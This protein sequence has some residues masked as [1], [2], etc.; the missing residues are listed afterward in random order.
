M[1][2]FGQQLQSREEAARRSVA[3]NLRSLGDI[4][5]GR[6]PRNYESDTTSRETI[7]Q[8][9]LILKYFKLDIPEKP[10]E[11]ENILEQIDAL[12][13]PSGAMRRR[14]ILSGSWWKDGDGPILATVKETGRVL[15]LLPGLLDGYYYLDPQ[16]GDKIRITKYNRGLFE[17]DA[18]C[19]YKPLPQESLTG[20]EYIAFLLQQ[21]RLSDLILL[22]LAGL[23]VT[24]VGILIPLVTKIAFT[25]IVPTGKVKM[26][27]SLTLM[28]ASTAVGGWLM[29]SV[30]DSMTERIRNRLDTSAQNAVFSRLLN[31]PVTFF[32]NK[33]SGGLAQQVTALN[34]LPS[35]LCD[36]LLCGMLTVVLSLADIYPIFSASVSL[37]LPSLAVLAASVGLFWVTVLQER[38]KIRS[39]LSAS[40]NNNAIVYDFLMGI[41]KIKLSGSENMA[42][43]KWL[44]VYNKKAG[45]FFKVQFPASIRGQLLTFIRLLGTLWTFSI[46][47]RQGLSAAQFAVFASAYGL[48]MSGIDTL[49]LYGNSFSCL[50]PVLNIGEPILQEVPEQSTG[51]RT[52]SS[53]TGKIELHEVT[54]RYFEDGPAILDNV[55]LSI[56]P[57]EYVAIVGTTGCGKSTFMKLLLG[58]LSPQQGSITY[59]DKDLE[60]IDKR[61]FRRHVG[62]VLQD[63]KLFP[64]DILDNITIAAPWLTPDDAWEA[65]QK[66]GIADYIRSLPMGMNTFITEG[67]GSISGGQRQR[68]II[69][70][71]IATNANILMFDEATSALDNI[72]QKVVTDSL[73]K[74][75][76]T[77]I[78]I[79]HRLS[80]IRDCDRILV[81]DQ[82]KIAESGT[83]DELIARKGFFAELVSRQLLSDP[84]FKPKKL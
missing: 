24:F 11:Y 9:G 20:R 3:Q 36:I 41:Q 33:S 48:M 53:L 66:A 76:C 4:V 29:R 10:P 30:R 58:F 6:K 67:S 40:V 74:M 83:Y 26:L 69:A 77:R 37:V 62:V 71:A 70:R 50:R 73:S 60:R 68:I 42:F 49:A 61:S 5:M 23:G 75:G 63:G 27:L 32:D 51:K 12:L 72:T 16:S 47:F 13:Q 34:T 22:G 18:F 1:S 35:L 43:A 31:L 65:A 8:I 59:D 57:G 19:F 81:L 56:R 17:E 14:I 78:V 15:A 7:R 44:E 79:A 38:S 21:L 25:G 55:S 54:F 52:V 82:G 39:L 80:T 64:G 46:A 45:A 2:L 84:S 28:L